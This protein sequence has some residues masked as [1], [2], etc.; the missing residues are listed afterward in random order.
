MIIIQI[1][2]FALGRSTLKASIGHLS[3]HLKRAE[4]HSPSSGPFQF[5][6]VPF[7]FSSVTQ[8]CPI[9]CEPMDCSTPGFL[10]NHQTLEPAQ[11][12]VHWV[13]DAIQPSHPLSSLSPPAF[14]ISQQHQGLFKWLSSSHQVA[15]MLEFQLQHQ[16]F[17]WTFRVDFL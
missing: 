1:S 12:H 14:N 2:K 7:Q 13:N 17:Q 11:T 10:V 4:T 6:S 3:T 8:L 9:L 5:S 16:S 15:K